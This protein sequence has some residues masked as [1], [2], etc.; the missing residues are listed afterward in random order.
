MFNI[1]I[2]IVNIPIIVVI[3][4][5]STVIVTYNIKYMKMLFSYYISE[6]FSYSYLAQCSQVALIL[7]LSRLKMPSFSVAIQVYV[8][9]ILEGFLVTDK[10]D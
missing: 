10:W 6:S 3:F 1:S 7:V 8:F 9:E 2:V 5:I 4:N